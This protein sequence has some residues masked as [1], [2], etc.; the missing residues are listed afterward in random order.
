MPHPHGGPPTSDDP[1]PNDPPPA[2][3]RPKDQFPELPVRIFRNGK[4]QSVDLFREMDFDETR[5]FFNAFDDIEKLR[6]WLI[7]FT[8][9]IIEDLRRRNADG[10]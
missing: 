9:F 4:W 6:S 3:S 10:S 7:G 1:R 8:K 5:V 2:G